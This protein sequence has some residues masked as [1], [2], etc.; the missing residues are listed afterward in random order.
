MKAVCDTNVLVSAFIAGGP[1]RRVLEA[2]RDGAIELVLPEIAL[3]ELART[4]LAKLGAGRNE[5][6][7]YVE[8]LAE[9]AATA[10]SPSGA[11]V[12]QSPADDATLACAVA[13][14]ADAL[15]TG[16]RRHL[17]PLDNHHNVRILA[18]QAL[19]AELRV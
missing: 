13:E 5:L 11:E 15:V 2:A 17:L 19:L 4:L 1:P 6:V 16:D 10:P 9:T 18:P 14:S 7:A 12:T 8:I 3:E